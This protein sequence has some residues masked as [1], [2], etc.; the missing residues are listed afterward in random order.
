MLRDYSSSTLLQEYTV[1]PSCYFNLYLL[2]IIFLFFIRLLSFIAEYKCI[3]EVI[4]FT[5]LSRGG[6][7]P[8]GASASCGFVH[9]IIFSAKPLKDSVFLIL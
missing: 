2:F 8:R 5:L 9:L 3:A 7:T 4:I 6:A 1:E